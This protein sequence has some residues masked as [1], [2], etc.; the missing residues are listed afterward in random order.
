L[1]TAEHRYLAPG[2]LSS[3]SDKQESFPLLCPV[4]SVLAER[5]LSG[6]AGKNFISD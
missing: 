5:T 3:V 1:T 6:E 2:F 4:V